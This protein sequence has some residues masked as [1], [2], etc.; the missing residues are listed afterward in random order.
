MTKGYKITILTTDN[1]GLE[2]NL[3]K[4]RK[5]RNTKGI[6]IEEITFV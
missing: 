1:W 2:Y 4:I 6:F 3:E 5:S